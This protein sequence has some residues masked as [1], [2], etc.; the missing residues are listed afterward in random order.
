M[1]HLKYLRY[2]IV[3][4]WFVMLACFRHGLYW[5]GIVHDWSK[6]LPDEWFPYVN[7]FY[8]PWKYSERPSHVV[9]AFDRAWLKHQHRNPH[10]WQHWILREDSGAI[11]VLDMPR[12][13]RLEMLCDWEGAGRAITG[14]K[15]VLSWYL[16]NRDRIQLSPLTQKRV[17][18]SLHISAK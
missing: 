5:Q 14:K 4:K 3:H 11:K 12:R 1:K 2:V 7:T 6:F 9:A 15:D 17:D 16:K 10:H 13:Y 8:G 18:Y